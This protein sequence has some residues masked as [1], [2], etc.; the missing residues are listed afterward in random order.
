MGGRVL[1]I[2]PPKIPEVDH[3]GSEREREMERNEQTFCSNEK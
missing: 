2:S 3:W 1:G